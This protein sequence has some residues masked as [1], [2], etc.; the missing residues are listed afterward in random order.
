M[1]RTKDKGEEP[2]TK[3]KNQKTE[4]TKGVG[5]QQP[6]QRRTIHKSKI[7]GTASG[8]SLNTSYPTLTLTLTLTKL[9]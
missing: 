4:E 3:E 7:S 5:G 9:G 8:T 1:R 2:K 6:R